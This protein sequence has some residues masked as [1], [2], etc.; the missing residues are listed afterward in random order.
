MFL[1][2]NPEPSRRH[3]APFLT[4]LLG[5]LL[6]VRSGTTVA[7]PL[8]IELSEG[9]SYEKIHGAKSTY[10]DGVIE[11]V[12]FFWYG[13]PH[14]YEI[15][16]LLHE[17]GKK[18]PTDVRFEPLAL[19]GSPQ[20]TLDAKVYFAARALS[21]PEEFHRNFFLARHSANHGSRP[22]GRKAI[23]EFFAKSYGDEFNFD[24]KGFLDVMDSFSVAGRTGA[25]LQRAKSLGVSSVPEIVIDG[26]FRVN[27]RSAGSMANIFKVVDQLLEL[28]RAEQSAKAKATAKAKVKAKAKAKPTQTPAPVSDDDS[29]ATKDGKPKKSGE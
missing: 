12:E 28:V 8:E 3:L 14:C 18:L 29:V 22:I 19:A 17:W 4:V 16:P 7:E 5:L 21:L 13:C 24:G 26:R 2:L 27:Q 20:W 1:F 23:G 15:L 25:V 6:C 11:V 10:R 9:V